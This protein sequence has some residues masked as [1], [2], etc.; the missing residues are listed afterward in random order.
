MFEN[1]FK[2]KKAKLEGLN[3]LNISSDSAVEF[4]TGVLAGKGLYRFK[5]VVEMTAGTR[6]Y[7]R[8]VIYSLSEEQEYILEVF[9][10]AIG[11][12]KEIY[13][14]CIADTVPF[15][16]EFLMEV[17]GQRF[18]NTPDGEEY[19]RNILPEE[20]NRMDGI[21][22]NASVYNVMTGEMESTTQLEIWDYSL[23]DE[24]GAKRYLNLEMRKDDGM[25][26]IFKGE[27]IEDIFMK[28]YC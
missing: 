18:L 3:P 13:L 8:Y 11:S 23:V 22:I 28:V 20:E 2:K 15:S 21:E 5:K 17:A 4:K 25:F 10:S 26:R 24:T 7:A 19:Q 12:E 9:P 1:L 14:Y 16:E 27:L 6:Q